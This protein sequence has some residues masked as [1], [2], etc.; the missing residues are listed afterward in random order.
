MFTFDPFFLRYTS[1]M[2]MNVVVSEFKQGV[3]RLPPAD[4]ALAGSKD[5][6]VQGANSHL[7]QGSL[8]LQGYLFWMHAHVTV[9]EGCGI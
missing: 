3:Y 4:R 8:I 9:R 6:P 7:H 2:V 1:L 5:L